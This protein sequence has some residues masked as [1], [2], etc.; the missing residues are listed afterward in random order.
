MIGVSS[1]RR[2]FG[3]SREAVSAPADGGVVFSR[4]SGEFF[5]D[6]GSDVFAEGD[7]GVGGE[8]GEVFH[9]VARKGDV[10]AWTFHR[11]TGKEGRRSGGGAGAGTRFGGGGGN[12]RGGGAGTAVA[13]VMDCGVSFACAAGKLGREHVADELCCRHPLFERKDH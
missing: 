7:F 11:K 6:G 2:G 10:A 13:A 1:A 8:A 4:F 3:G 5:Q 9:D 12:G